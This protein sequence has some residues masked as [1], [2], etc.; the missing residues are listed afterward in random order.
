MTTNLALEYIPRRMAELGFGNEYYLRFRHF[1]LQPTEQLEV[2]AFNQFFILVDEASDVSVNSEFGIFDLSLKNANE[3]LYEH[4]G[5]IIIKNHASA[6]NHL[7]FI[8]VIPR[9]KTI[10]DEEQ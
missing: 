1:V 5:Q 10:C 2:S 3:M 4:Q 7:R 6:I 8:Q 9:H